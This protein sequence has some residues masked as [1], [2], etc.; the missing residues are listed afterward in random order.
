M[1]TVYRSLAPCCHCNARCFSNPRCGPLYGSSGTADS[2]SANLA[3]GASFEPGSGAQTSAQLPEPRQRQ[4]RP[5]L[6]Q[7]GC[8]DSP[9]A[10]LASERR[11][12]A[13][14]RPCS[15]LKSGGLYLRISQCLGAPFATLQRQRQLRTLYLRN[16][17]IFRM[18]C[19]ILWILSSGCCSSGAPFA[20]HRRQRWLPSC[21]GGTIPA[22]SSVRPV[23]SAPRR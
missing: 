23:P 20:I 8:D 5:W 21:R 9:A 12:N 16:R 18:A 10:N 2:L 14:V 11:E 6:R 15:C 7:G 19:R 1:E 17:S 22:S 4:L 3:A 13:L